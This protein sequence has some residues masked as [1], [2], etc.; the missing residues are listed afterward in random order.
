MNDGVQVL[1]AAASLSSPCTDT[2]CNVDAT[3]D[4]TV[5]DGIEVLRQA[6]SLAAN[7]TC[8]TRVSNF[9]DGVANTDGTQATMNIGPAPIPGAGAPTT[10]GTPTGDSTAVAGGSNEVTVPFDASA[11]AA[12]IAGDPNATLVFSVADAQGNLFDGF[13]ELPLSA[14]SGQVTLD[15]RFPETLGPDTFLLCPATRVNGELSNYAILQQDPVQGAGAAQ[16][17]FN[18]QPM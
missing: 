9:V 6:A 12:A 18:F 16:V 14:L 13:Y 17:T 15:V 4:V 3:G 1:R 2:I 8:G 7:V 5:N 11:A 10:V